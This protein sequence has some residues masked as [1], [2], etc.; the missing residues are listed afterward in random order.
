[1]TRTQENYVR[2]TGEIVDVPVIRYTKAGVPNARFFLRSWRRKKTGGEWTRVPNTFVVTAWNDLA[3]TAAT[4]IESGDEVTIVGELRAISYTAEN[5]ST[6]DAVEIA[7][8]QILIPLE[9]CAG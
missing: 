9:E 1:M 5:G 4:A 3:E 8:S 7:A 2:I 6:V